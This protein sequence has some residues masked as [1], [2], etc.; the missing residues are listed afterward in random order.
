MKTPAN[1]PFN[2]YSNK[3]MLDYLKHIDYRNWNTEA[4]D[5]KDKYRK[6][7]IKMKDKI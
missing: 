2:S 7:L 6:L 4:T 1:I 3:N 5:E